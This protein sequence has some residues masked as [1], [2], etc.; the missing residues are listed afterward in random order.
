[1]NPPWLKVRDCDEEQQDNIESVR[2]DKNKLYVMTGFRY[3]DEARTN[4]FVFDKSSWKAVTEKV[5]SG[6]SDAFPQADNERIFPTQY[7]SSEGE[8][9]T[10]SY[11]VRREYKTDSYPDSTNYIFYK[12]DK[13]GNSGAGVATFPMQGTSNSTPIPV[14]NKDDVI[15]IGNPD[16]I[17]RLSLI[18]FDPVTSN[19]VTFAVL[20]TIAAWAIDI[21]NIYVS[22]GVDILIFDLANFALKSV[23][24]RIFWNDGNESRPASGTLAATILSNERAITNIYI[25]QGKMI[26]RTLYGTSR[27][28]DIPN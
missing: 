26:V 28:F 16:D 27:A 13:T 9:A 2:A 24:P 6:G 18:H 3:P 23:M 10:K 17:G 21:N 8:F 15:F 7:S 20:P 1:L 19:S 25:D 4:Y 22:N 12:N 14:P 5:F 11:R